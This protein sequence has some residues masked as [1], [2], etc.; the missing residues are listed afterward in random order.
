[1]LEVMSG[2]TLEWSLGLW[3]ASVDLTKALDRVEHAALFEALRRQGLRESYVALVSEMYD[4]QVGGLRGSKQFVIKR[5]VRQGDVLSPLLFNSALEDAVARWKRR[6]ARHG[7]QLD[8]DDSA[9]RLTNV[10]FA[11]DLMLY[12]KSEQE[13]IYMLDTLQEEL[14]A[15]GLQLN[16][17]KT[18]VLTTAAPPLPNFLATAAGEVEVLLG[19]KTHK[20]LGKTLV[21]RS[22]DRARAAV[23]GR[24]TAAWGKWYQHKKTL[25]N[26]K[27]PLK[28]RLKLF[29]A[30]VCP[31]ATYSLESS[32]VAKS[33]AQKLD[34]VQRK[35]LRAL[36]GWRR[37][38]D[39]SWHTTM[40]R[41]RERVARAMRIHRVEPWSQSLL[42]KKYRL[43]T[44][45][46][47]ADSTSWARRV[48]NW[49][50]P[51]LEQEAA[52]CRF[53]GRPPRRWDDDLNEFCGGDGSWMST[54]GTRSEDDFALSAR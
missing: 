50:P 49:C 46:A 12:A 22:A 31:A 20:Y 27:I 17:D 3:T 7:W 15:S 21:G 14:A 32:T 52:P 29:S 13:L 37:K 33:H 41:M 38:C 39:E 19:E 23:N 47:A 51:A 11:D 36:A 44:K 4:G 54:L 45:V 10:R 34:V 25:V 24:V 30:V 9:E 5:G 35:M 16:P 40:R 42:R 8:A 53:A 43:A 1:M 2:K 6:L 28:L 18:K 48:V 26:Q